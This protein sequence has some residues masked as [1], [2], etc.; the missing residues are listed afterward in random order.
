M[1]VVARIVSSSSCCTASNDSVSL[2]E[3]F[4]SVTTDSMA[5]K[6]NI[7]TD[8]K[9]YI[10]IYN[11]IIIMIIYLMKKEENNKCVFVEM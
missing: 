6:M 9:K 2:F 11:K 4:Q 10:Y 5:R 7:N 1:T 3:F 8:F